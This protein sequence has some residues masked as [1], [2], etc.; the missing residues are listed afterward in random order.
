M[1]NKAKRWI[2]DLEPYKPGKPIEELE[3]ELGIRDSVKIASNE[4]PLGPS[5][6]A[7]TAIGAA[8]AN[9]HRYPDGASFN[10]RGALAD[11]LD[12]PAEQFVFGNGSSEILELLAKVY[13][14]PEAEIVYAW[15]SFAMYPIVAKG[16]GART[17]EVPL[18]ADHVHDLDAMAAAVTD[19]TGLVIVCNPNNP[20][21]TS[22][23]AS[24][25]DAFADELPA[26]VILVIDEA[27]VEYARR[28]DFPNALAI[29]RRRPNTIV[30]RTFSKIYGLAGMRV[31]YSISDPEIAGLLERSRHPFNVNLLAEIAATAALSD[32]DHVERSRANNAIGAETL[33]RELGK[34]GIRTW[35]TDANFMLAE[36]GPAAY[37]ELL[38]LG[39]IVRPMGGYD[40]PECVRLS[41]GTPEE[42]ERLIKA[43]QSIQE[44]AAS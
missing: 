16:M 29:V 18:T 23:S 4:N 43:L 40:M 33:E 3:R 12:L 10:L 5:P 41:I 35:P 30:L 22:V 27:Y 2:L 25:L 39:V 21:G 34:L 24:E 15:P 13:L 1:T 32:A 7:I 38:Q 17:V 6:K 28:D 31:G 14:G 44:R 20:T 8:A 37:E 9:V 42:N 11:R 19:A 26:D 36:T